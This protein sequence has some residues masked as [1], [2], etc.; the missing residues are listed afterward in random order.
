MSVIRV[1]CRMRERL[2]PRRHSRASC[3]SS[4][5]H[6]GDTTMNH[7][8]IEELS[9]AKLMAVI[10]I[11]FVICWVPQLMTIILAQLEGSISPVPRMVYRIADI[12]IAMNFTID[13]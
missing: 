6:G 5:S 11:F 8:T 10:S 3:R 9:F 12:F 4:S 7:A 1:L 13:P 2:M